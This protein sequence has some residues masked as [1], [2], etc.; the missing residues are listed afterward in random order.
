DAIM[1]NN[2]QNITKYQAFSAKLPAHTL[3]DL[4][5]DLFYKNIQSAEKKRSRADIACDECR[6]SKKKCV[7]LNQNA[8]PFISCDRCR[9]SNI[10]CIF[11]PLCNFCKKKLNCDGFC[12]NLSCKKKSNP[13][14]PS[15]NEIQT[16]KND[17]LAEDKLL[18]DDNLAINEYLK[19]LEREIQSLKDDNLAINEYLKKL[20]RE[21]QS[22][23]DDNQSLKDDNL[24]KDE[25]LKKLEREF[26]LM[27]EKTKLLEGNFAAK[28]KFYFW[29]E[30]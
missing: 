14:N 10:E 27:K 3:N 29:F 26:Q 9:K 4:S 21:F 30:N 24:A 6:K 1:N 11:T 25:Y 28:D 13:E 16:L 2:K 18:K 23:K 12:L 5:K 22:L 15:Y 8:I 17:I 19:K 20:E 7:V